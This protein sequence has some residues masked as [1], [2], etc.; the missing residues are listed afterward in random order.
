MWQLD[1]FIY[2]NLWRALAGARLLYWRLGGNKMAMISKEEVQKIATLSK[3]VLDEAELEAL[4]GD[5]EK[6]IAFADKI[7]SAP[8]SDAVFEGIGGGVNVL[9][10][11]VV[12]PSLDRERIL[13]NVQGGENGYFPVKK[14]V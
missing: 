2:T 10:E 12:K 6:I 14:R 5:M 11:D 8:E 1:P 3:L 9:R 7:K 13:H 4:T